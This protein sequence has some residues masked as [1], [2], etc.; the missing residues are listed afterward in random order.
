MPEIVCV[1]DFRFRSVSRV[2]VDC[3]A[4]ARFEVVFGCHVYRGTPD[5]ASVFHMEAASA[6]RLGLAVFTYDLNAVEVHLPVSWMSLSG[7]PA[8]A[9]IVASP[10]LKL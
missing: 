1:R 7:Q 6:A 10:A 2:V 8:L 4:A 5:S 9:I 3:N